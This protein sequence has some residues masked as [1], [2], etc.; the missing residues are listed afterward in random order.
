MAGDALRL[1]Q[2]VMAHS[3][4]RFLAVDDQLRCVA[5]NAA[6]SETLP[7]LVKGTPLESRLDPARVAL[8]R[9]ALDGHEVER[10]EADGQRTFRVRLGPV[11]DE[12]GRVVGAFQLGRDVTAEPATEAPFQTFFETAPLMMG[13][14]ELVDDDILHLFDN[15][16]ACAFFGK[17]TGETRGKLASALGAPRAVIDEWR[18]HYRHAER[19]GEPVHFDYWHGPERQHHTVTVAFIGKGSSGR[20]R[21]SYAVADTT[22]QKRIEEAL[23]QA[24]TTLEH[25]VLERTRELERSREQL[26][27]AVESARLGFYDWDVTVDRLVVSDQMRADWGL[28]PDEELSSLEAALARLHPD[29]REKAREAIERALATDDAEALEFRVILPDGAV[30]WIEIK[31]VVRRTEG[32]GIR[33]FGTSLDITERKAAL[34]ALRASEVRFRSVM[35]NMS[36]GI[37]LFEPTGDLIYQN[38]ASLRIHEFEGEEQGRLDRTKV[39]VTWE[40][41]ELKTGRAITFDEWPISRVLR[42][43][44]FRDQAYR[45]RRVDTGR[46]FY[47]SYNGSPIRDAEGKIVLGFI[48]IRDITE[49]VRADAE[50][51]TFLES[52]PQMAFVADAK[53]EILYYNR[54]H[55]EYFAAHPGEMEA[56]GWKDFPTL[57]PDDVDRTIRTW[58]TSIE[59]GEP[60]E[61]EYRLRRY[62][63]AF[64]WHLGRA[65]PVRDDRGE[66]RRWIGTNTDISEQKANRDYLASLIDSI[67]HMV[68]VTDDA[69]RLRQIN[70]GYVEYTGMPESA[71]LDGWPGML[72]PADRERCLETWSAAVRGGETYLCNVRMRRHDGE[73]RWHVA[74]GRRYRHEDGTAL[75]FGTNTDVHDTTLHSDALRRSNDELARFAYVASHDLKEPLRTVSAYSQLLVRNFG[76]GQS[77]AKTYA[78]FI[79]DGVRRMYRLI[80]DLLSFSSL[81]AGEHRRIP[82]DTRRVVDLALENLQ[83]SIDEAGA[84]VEVDPLPVVLGDERELLPLFQNLI[85]NAIKYRGDTRPAVRVS[86]QGRPGEHVFTVTDNG[87][88]IPAEFHDKIFVLFQRL[89]AKDA[90][91]GTGI[92]L[93]VCKKIVER[94][95]GRI[96][97]RSR[98]GEGSSFH[99]T[100]PTAHDDASRAAAGSTGQ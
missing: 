26:A 15:A 4:D 69:G 47:G 61:I 52:M 63:G 60:Y 62:D 5:W 94:H 64:R 18:R 33:F 84:T 16:R 17:A 99:F 36:E 89:H 31:N 67:P 81:G 49:Q 73:Y 88:G 65:V 59:S 71:L 45:V 7:D 79:T 80:D 2:T 30:R 48:T 54:Q 78:Q 39:P 68:W 8:W 20:S 85:G 9:Q 57:H 41:W 1:L 11:R 38:A 100:L 46:E 82:V 29:D 42:G 58:A 44:R 14:V 10:L 27:M 22:E 19:S 92:G 35:E 90:Y 24:T 98:P 56:S 13:C 76:G 83:A 87:I 97:V 37:M 75:W 86:A 28:R 34:E 50:L 32:G 96:W 53:G 70:R 3:R 21:F 25:R 95:G 55:Y 77:E 72:H 43:E 91:S 74:Q 51:K 6:A 93:A 40:A 23:R 66:I 12:D